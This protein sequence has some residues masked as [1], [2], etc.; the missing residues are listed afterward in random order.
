VKTKLTPQSEVS[1]SM[2]SVSC[3]SSS[4][5]T[6]TKERRFVYHTSHPCRMP[7]DSEMATEDYPSTGTGTSDSGVGDIHHYTPSYNALRRKLDHL[8][9][10]CTET[11]FEIKNFAY[12]AITL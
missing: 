7:D 2:L 4:P 10:H 8:S 12:I 3:Q 9:L 1:Q 11:N 5:S 6:S